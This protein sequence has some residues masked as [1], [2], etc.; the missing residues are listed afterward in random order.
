MTVDQMRLLIDSLLEQEYLIA[1][2][3]VFTATRKTKEVSF[4][5]RFKEL[6]K[7]FSE[8]YEEKTAFSINPDVSYIPTDF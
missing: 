5:S 6:K 1:K 8:E 2:D 7:A 3:G 4:R